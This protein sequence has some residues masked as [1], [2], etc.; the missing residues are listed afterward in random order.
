MD[1]KEFINKIRDDYSPNK[2]TQRTL[3]GYSSSIKTLAEDLYSKDTHFIFELIQNAEDNNYADDVSPTL[4]FKIAEINLQRKKEIS[5]IIENNETGFEESHVDAICKIGK[6]TKDKSQGYIGEKGIG[7]KSVFKIT[8]SPSIFSNGFQFSLPENDEETKLGYIVPKWIDIIP[9]EINRDWT[10]IILPLNKEND[11]VNNLLKYLEEIEPETILFLKRIKKIEIVVDTPKDNYKIVIE[12][13]DE[14]YP[15]V[16]LIHCKNA[17]GFRT[18]VYWINSEEFDKP[19]YAY[20]DKRPK[21][22]KRVVSVALPLNKKSSQQKLF[23]YLPVWE[24]TGIP[25]L[26]NADFLLV[27]SREGIHEEESWNEWLRDCIS[28]VYRE[29]VLSCL[30]SDLVSIDQNMPYMPLYPQ[31]LT[32][33]F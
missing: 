5:L 26:I 18:A 24:E 32:I 6:S 33:L 23:A 21:T 3:E 14:S 10:T 25:F 15:L 16:K 13:K 28:I 31:R 20:S 4:R 1:K 2:N 30:Q 19:E 29:G 9:N 7:F 12:K 22:Q 11:A 27:S 8:N 17:E